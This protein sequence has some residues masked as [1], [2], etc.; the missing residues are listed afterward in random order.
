[1]QEQRNE[2]GYNFCEEKGCG[3]SDG[4][5]DCSHDKSVNDCQREGMSELAYDKNNI[6]IRCRDCHIIWDSKY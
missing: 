1:L 6:T 4:Y 3:R 5:I 2:F